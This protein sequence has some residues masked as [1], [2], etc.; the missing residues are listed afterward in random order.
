MAFKPS[1]RSVMPPW[2]GGPHAEHEAH[3]AQSIEALMLWSE[4][5]RLCR[6]TA[7]DQAGLQPLHAAPV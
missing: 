3:L 7:V 5:V 1:S 4:V 2:H 6:C